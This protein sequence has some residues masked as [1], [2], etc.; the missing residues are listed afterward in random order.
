MRN[1]GLDT[2]V[3]RIRCRDV[4]ADLS[5]YVDGALGTERVAAL[6]AHLSGCE[7]SA[8]FGGTFVRVLT[9]LRDGLTEP[10]ALEPDARARLHANVADAIRSPR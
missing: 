6:Q 7:R 2:T 5:D 3:A 1:D 4:L 8:R 9:A 10:P